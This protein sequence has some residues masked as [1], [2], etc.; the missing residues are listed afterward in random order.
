MS[1]TILL[2]GGFG[3]LGGR[4]AAHLADLQDHH[5]VLA[6]R[7]SRAAPKWA[8]DAQTIRLDITDPTT[9]S[10]IPK[11]I[12]CVIQLA[13]INDADSAQKPELAHRV[14]AEGTKSLLEQS[15]RS[16]IER[17][18]YFSTAHVYGAP[19]VGRFTEES[20]ALASHPYASTH[21]LAESTVERA[22]DCGDIT[23]IRLRISNG[24]GRPMSYETGDWRTLTSDL[25]RQAV[26]V[27]KMEMHTDGLQERNFI[28]KT[29]IAR[30]VQHL[31]A[32]PKTDVSNGLFN[33]GG[34]KS[35]TLLAMANMIQGRAQNKFGVE[36]PL[37]RPEPTNTDSQQLNFDV[38]K[39]LNTGFSLTE[40][41]LGEI[42]E[43]LD[44]IEL[45]HQS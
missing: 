14:T 11:S 29:D 8:P 12:D 22:N 7:T 42:D 18:V 37:H 30:A 43:F 45:H 28:T 15:V 9:F 26:T 4:I 33:L 24:F 36:I 44:M 39:L 32:L 41:A 38:H 19:L 6:S 17:F 23:G 13:G 35:Q 10:H 34:S 20:L 3:N 16:G 2:V 40:D 25:C 21:L 27:R 31:I 5:I 1:A